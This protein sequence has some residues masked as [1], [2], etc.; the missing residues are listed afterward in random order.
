[1]ATAGLPIDAIGPVI[2]DAP[3]WLPYVGGGTGLALPFE[4]PESVVD[5]GRH[6]HASVVVVTNDEHPL[7]A[8]LEAGAPGSECFQSVDIGRPADPALARALDG[9]HVYR[10]V[11]P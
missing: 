8:F 5:L 1:M 6:F 2:T 11:C 9:T 10:L 7:Q 3:I 4:P